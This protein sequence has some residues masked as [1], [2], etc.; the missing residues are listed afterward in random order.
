MK[1]I[2]ITVVTI[3]VIVMGFML[4]SSRDSAKED[5][6]IA[7]SV[8]EDESDT[9]IGMPVPGLGSG[10]VD[11]MI[12][13]FTVTYTDDGYTPDNL[14]IE[15]GDIVK[16]TNDSSSPNWPA[17]AVHPTHKLYPG[18]DIKNC[19]TAEDGSMFDSCQSIDRGETWSFTFDEIGEWPFHNHK[20]PYHTGIITVTE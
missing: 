4:I 10:S 16:F 6:D 3:V 9:S 14:K 1:N 20:K 7:R 18:S 8:T 2:I 5:R 11:E 15:K 19:S 12:A 13:V 17:S